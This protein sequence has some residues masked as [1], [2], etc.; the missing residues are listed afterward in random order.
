MKSLIFFLLVLVNPGR[1]ATIEPRWQETITR[2]WPGAELWANPAEDWTT[3]A[4]RIENTFPGGNR[5]LVPLTAELTPAAA[6]FTVRCR[7]DQVSLS[8][9]LQ[10]FAGIQVGLGAPSGDYREAVMLGTGLTA[11]VR[12]DG[13]LFIGSTLGAGAK[14]P[15]PLRLLT[16]ELRGAQRHRPFRPPPQQRH[17]RS[18]C[19]M[20]ARPRRVHR[21]QQSAARHQSGA[22]AP[23]RPAGHP[24]GPRRGFSHGL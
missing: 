3:K 20:A 14:I 13:T 17:H 8:T 1:A 15:F 22:K 16:L 23:A 2:P 12:Y 18:P 19:L 24:P 11:G 5:N 21:F 9:P 6:P 10:G 7:I 4:G